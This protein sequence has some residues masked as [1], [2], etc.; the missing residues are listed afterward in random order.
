MHETD[1]YSWEN[2]HTCRCEEISVF[3][4]CAVCGQTPPFQMLIINIRLTLTDGIR[5]LTTS[6]LGTL[7]F[8]VSS[9]SMPGKGGR[10]TKGTIYRPRA[11]IH[12]HHNT[13]KCL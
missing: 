4:S 8:V 6:T 2:Y 1:S 5:G 13:A 7:N 9:S 12:G 3:D 10:E 11:H